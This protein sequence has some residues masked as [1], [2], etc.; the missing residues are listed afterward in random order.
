MR[1][2]FAALTATL[3]GFMLASAPQPASAES[4][5]GKVG[6]KRYAVNFI[7]VRGNC[8]DAYKAYL[9]ASGHSAY[10]QT[11]SIR[12]NFICGAAINARSEKAAQ[13]Q[14]MRNCLG[15]LKRFKIEAKNNCQIYVSK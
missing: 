13:E 15:G 10:V 4:L 11:P 6:N 9:A 2:G 1:L 3:A 8:P 12:N 14:A 7:R 5:A